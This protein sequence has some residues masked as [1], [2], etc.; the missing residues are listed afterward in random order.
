MTVAVN[1]NVRFTS[2]PMKLKNLLLAVV[3]AVF[4]L[5][6]A[7]ASSG[8]DQYTEE[9]IP[10]V[11]SKPDFDQVDYR[12]AYELKGRPAAPAEADSL[13]V[14]YM[15]VGADLSDHRYPVSR[16]N[17]RVPEFWGSTYDSNRYAVSSSGFGYAEDIWRYQW[18]VRTDHFGDINLAFFECRFQYP[19]DFH[20][21]AAPM[22]IVVG[23]GLNFKFGR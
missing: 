10:P 4:P 17:Y 18:L 9:S 6:C 13:V 21:S 16:S 11:A 8:A 3:I 2:I 5:S 7:E 19:P 22:A 12:V 14:R 20:N 23:M 1:N 15:P